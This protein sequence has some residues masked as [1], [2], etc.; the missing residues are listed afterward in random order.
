MK[1]LRINFDK[2][3]R[4]DK[5][6]STDDLRPVF[7]NIFFEDGNMIAT[8]AHILVVNN[9]AECSSFKPE[10][11][12]IL[13]G[14]FIHKNDYAELLK[15]DIVSIKEDGFYIK[16][17]TRQKAILFNNIDKPFPNYKALFSETAKTTEYIGIDPTLVCKIQLALPYKRSMK[18]TFNGKNK[19][20]YVDCVDMEYKSKGLIMPRQIS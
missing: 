17:G 10:Q 15:S 1:K 14:K 11:I 18:L 13:N 9:I 20:I 7:E 19:T 5:V 12:E 3:I 8:N 4:I 2:D 16:N 6:C